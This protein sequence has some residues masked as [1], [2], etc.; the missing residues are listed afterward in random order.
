MRLKA[1]ILEKPV[2]MTR[3]TVYQQTKLKLL[4]EKVHAC[5]LCETQLPLG[6]RPVFQFGPE[7]PIL[8]VGQA[9]GR[10]VHE[11]GLPFNDPSGDRLRNWLGVNRV[12]FY[13]PA[14]FSLLPMGFCYPGT[15]KSGD[16][17]PRPECAATW[18]NAL[19]AQL[20]QLQLT[21]LLGRYAIDHHLGSKNQSI[22]SL[23]QNWQEHWPQCIALPHP[24]PRNNRWLRE[25]PWFETDIMPR[26]REQVSGL[27]D[28]K[29]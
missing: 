17:P 8:L 4:L 9:P 25:H 13:D 16:L 14:C 7:A 5:R 19:L 27:L 20:N 29:I 26:L 24:S 2:E 18:R 21:V 23:C 28:G 6:P 12:Q 1:A 11:T 3:R 10:R 22:S 15:G